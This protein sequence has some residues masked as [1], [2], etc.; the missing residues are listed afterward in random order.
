MPSRY[1][2]F[3]ALSVLLVKATCADAGQKTSFPCRN[4][5]DGRFLVDGPNYS[6]MT[7]SLGY[8]APPAY[9]VLKFTRK[10]S[11]DGWTN[12]ICLFELTPV[13]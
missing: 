9:K 8:D 13:R 5:G 1:V 4:M 11:E 3:L 6:A 2:F 10:A 7:R 12:G